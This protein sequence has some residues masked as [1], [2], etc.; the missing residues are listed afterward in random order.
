M[1]T[2]PDPIRDLAFFIYFFD[3]NPLILNG[4]VENTVD[5]K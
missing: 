3:C 2:R 4:D 1:K 5:F